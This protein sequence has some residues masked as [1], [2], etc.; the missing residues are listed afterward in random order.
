MRQRVSLARAIVHQPPA[1]LLDEPTNGLD[2]PSSQIILNFIRESRREGQAII[3]CTH[4]MEHAED[5]CNRIVVLEQGRILA[6]GTLAELQVRTGKLRLSDLFMALTRDNTPPAA[7][8]E[9][10]T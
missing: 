10:N 3:F 8:L 2:V 7:G 6:I 5:V 9:V 1:L 4:I